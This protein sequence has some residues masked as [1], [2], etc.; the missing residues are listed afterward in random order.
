MHPNLF[1]IARPTLPPLVR[2]GPLRTY[3]RPSVY[4]RSSSRPLSTSTTLLP[5][6][7]FVH[8]SQ[9][10]GIAVTAMTPDAMFRHPPPE[11]GAD[12]NVVMIGAGN[13]MFGS[14]EGPWNHSFRFEHK[15]GP[16]L[17]VTALIDPSIGRAEKVL[18]GKRQSFVESAYKNT[19]VFRTIEDYYAALKAQGGG[20]PHAIVVGCPP[21]YRGGTTKGTDLEINLLKLFPRT[22]YFVEKPV[23]TGT[24]EAAKE[25]TQKLIQNGNIV[26]VGYMLRYLRCV[27]KMKQ[28]IHENHLTVMATNARYSCAYEAI[29]KPAWWNKAIDMGPVIEQG[30]HF[31]DLSRYFGGDVDISSVIARSVEWYETPGQ[32]TKIPI[33]ESKIDE[34]Y[35]IPRLTSAIWK[36]NNGA[37]GSFQHAVALQGHDYSCELEVWADGYHMRLVDP[38]NAPCLYVRRPGVLDDHE[39]RHSFTDDDPFF[40]EVSS[41]IDC[42]EGGPDPHIL[43]SFEDATKTYE[44]TWAI[45]IA[46][47]AARQ[48]K[49]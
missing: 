13:I 23:G 39:E 15:L 42:I 33:D 10:R 41:F 16:R 4:R 26:S 38:Y 43:S 14:D 21:A 17:K 28:I 6:H 29:A 5:R 44:L 19:Q 3:V 9:S 32:L 37:V 47:E 48:P 46:S 12:F 40:S 20:D 25:V 22:A 31:C 35:R 45:R 8:P 18:E 49:N 30:T 2:L 1:A 11:P 27:Q 36:Y 7:G 34:E 24:V